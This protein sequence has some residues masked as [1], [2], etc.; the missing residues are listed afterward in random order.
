VARLLVAVEGGHLNRW[1]DKQLA[2]ID[3]QGSDLLIN[4]FE[5]TWGF[6]I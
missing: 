6:V 1:K 5:N 4:L 3:V 2:D